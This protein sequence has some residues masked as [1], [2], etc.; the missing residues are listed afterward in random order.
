MD[1]S[2][3]VP[4]KDE[5][6]NVE[7]LHKALVKALEPTGY[8][9]EMILVD[10]GSTDG[11]VDV[12][13]EVA[14]ADQRVKVI[15]LRRNYGQTPALRAGIDAAQGEVVITMDG[16]L[17][18]D[19]S[20]IPML[21]AKLGEGYDV[22]LGERVNRQDKLFV[23]KVPSWLANALIRKVTGTK[24]RD[25]GCTLRAMRREAAMELPLYGEMH[26]FMSVLAEISG[27]RVCQVPVKHHPRQ[28]GKTKY[29]L[30]RTVRVVLDLITVRFLQSYLTRPMHVFGLS[31]LACFGFA[32]TSLLTCGLQKLVW[33]EH[34][35]RNP[36]LLL[37]VLLTV[38]GVQFI[39]LGL[40]GEVLSRTYFESQGKT[41]YHIRKTINLDNDVLDATLNLGRRKVA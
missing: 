23:R 18:N 22:V 31:G 12:L 9:F 40:I 35:N 32:F 4:M 5:R 3:I 26:R 30:S 34:L 39:S 33:A 21:L 15:Q 36:L 28:F 14:R 25:L 24:I 20:D 2:I 38:V 29:N 16:D 8:T 13:A 17:Q 10:D 11:T 27:H 41:A 19:P 6:D 1:L 7:P 37:S